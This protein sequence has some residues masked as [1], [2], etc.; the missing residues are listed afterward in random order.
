MG[1]G[2]ADRGYVLSKGCGMAS[3]TATEL[4]ARDAARHAYVAA[5]SER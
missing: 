1:L 5:P 2:I 3:G 4:L